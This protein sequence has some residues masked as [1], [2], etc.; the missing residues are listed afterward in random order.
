MTTIKWFPQNEFKQMPWAARSL[1]SAAGCAETPRPRGFLIS[2]DGNLS[3]TTLRFPSL[4]RFSNS[5]TLG[6]G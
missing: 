3:P 1:R 5:E 2:K 4:T 6:A